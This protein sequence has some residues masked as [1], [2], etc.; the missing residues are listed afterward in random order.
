MVADIGGRMLGSLY[1]RSHLLQHSI[2][3]VGYVYQLPMM[4]VGEQFKM[5]VIKNSV[6]AFACEKF[7]NAESDYVPRWRQ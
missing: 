5:V 7:L 4:K 1:I 3:E 2:E 6:P